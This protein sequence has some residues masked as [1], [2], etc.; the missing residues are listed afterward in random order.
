VF[1]AG[2][3]RFS[4]DSQCVNGKRTH[5]EGNVLFAGGA[6]GTPIS[7]SG[8]TITVDDG[9]PGNLDPSVLAGMYVYQGGG[10]AFGGGGSYSAIR[11]GQA[12][13]SGYSWGTQG[14]LGG[15]ISSDIGKSWVTSSVTYS[16]H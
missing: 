7:F 13:S 12:A 16:I 10:G 11:F 2:Y 8:S 1:E 4:A 15:G 14:G 6:F 5:A 9:V 3:G